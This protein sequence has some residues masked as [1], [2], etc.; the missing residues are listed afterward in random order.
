ME[1]GR[2]T[3]LGQNGLPGDQIIEGEMRHDPS[4]GVA[5]DID[6]VEQRS[7]PLLQQA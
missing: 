3:C 7:E 4:G 1:I 6:Q 2:S 5:A